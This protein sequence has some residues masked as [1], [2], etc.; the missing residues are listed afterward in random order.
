MKNFLTNLFRFL[1]FFLPVYC[2]YLFVWGQFMPAPINKNLNYRIGSTGHMY[3]RI[4]DVKNFDG[5]DI[6]FIGSSLSYR[7]F[8]TR[9]FSK[10]NI[11][12]FNL[13]SSSQSP[14]QTEILLHRY[15]EGLNPKLVVFEVF[16]DT[17]ESDGVESSVDLIANDRI[18]L[19]TVKMALTVNHL[20]TYNTLLYGLFR[21]ILRLNEGFNEERK[22]KTTRDTYISGGFVEK[23]VDYH[24]VAVSIPGLVIKSRKME[25]N[26][27]QLAAF[28]R[29][30]QFVKRRN[31]PYVLVQAPITADLYKS[32]QN[33]REI[34]EY[35]H[36]LGVYYNFNGLL[37]LNDS[38]HYFDVHHLNRIG[39]ELLDAKLI[40]LLRQDGF[41]PRQ[42]SSK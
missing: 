17:F 27:K 1:G 36:S 21:Q 4:K 29:C 23:D 19:D 38:E 25:F 18:G 5:V 39:V 30:L 41:L 32:R 42:E 10:R 28:H 7:G 24:A 12:S 20:K 40:M 14:I 31:L 33:N 34:D 15:M 37:Q 35:F 2:V 3:S 16:P 26:K 13:G 6:L 11:S 9:I 22:C 8:D